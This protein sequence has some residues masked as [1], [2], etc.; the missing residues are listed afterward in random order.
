[1]AGYQELVAEVISNAR[2]DREKLEKLRDN[3]MTVDPQ[4]QAIID[5]TPLAQLGVAENVARIHDVLV[6]VNGQLVE[7]AKISAKLEN[8][9]ADVRQ[10]ADDIYDTIERSGQDANVS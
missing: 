3:L 5:E 8:P 10:D 6:K 4:Q 2:R 1:M 7:L 9:A